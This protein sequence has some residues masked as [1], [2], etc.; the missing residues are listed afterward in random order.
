MPAAEVL[1][2]IRHLLSGCKRC[3]S[4]GRGT[5]PRLLRFRAFV[6]DSDGV[7]SFECGT[8]AGRSIHSQF[9]RAL[10]QD[11]FDVVAGESDDQCCAVVLD[12]MADGGKRAVEKDRC[13]VDVGH[14]AAIGKTDGSINPSTSAVQVYC[15]R[16][17]VNGSGYL[18]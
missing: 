5:L 1:F 18:W 3:E 8:V 10:R 6:D 13:N 11:C 4:P 14:V 17:D 7:C 9:D 16:C 2:P 15:V 12:F